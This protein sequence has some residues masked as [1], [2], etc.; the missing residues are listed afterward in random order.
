MTR[1]STPAR[2]LS[3]VIKGFS[4]Q[5][6][7]R[8]AGAVRNAQVGGS[9]TTMVLG[10][11]S[12]K[13]IWKDEVAARTSVTASESAATALHDPN[14]ESQSPTRGASITWA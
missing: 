7:T 12:P 14:K 13:T 5:V 9:R 4:S 3:A 11:C 2:A 10:T 8:S 6:K 1:S